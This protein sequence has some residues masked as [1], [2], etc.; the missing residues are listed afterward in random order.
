[1]NPPHLLEID[2]SDAELV[3]ASLGGDASSFA[4]LVHRHQNLVT[5]M[6]YS[7]IGRRSAAEE[8]AQEAFVTAWRQ[9]GTL[10]DRSRLRA[11][12]A[13]ITRNLA[14]N[15]LRTQQ[16]ERVDGATISVEATSS[17]RS[18]DDE[19]MLRD[20]EALVDRT[21]ASLPEEYREVLI[22]YYRD[23][24]SAAVVGDALGLSEEAV[25][26]RLVRGR[27][28][29]Q[30]RVLRQVERTLR[31]TGPSAA[32]AI[33]VIALL[34]AP[35]AAAA[36]VGAGLSAVPLLS[37]LAMG[38]AAASIGARLGMLG[39]ITGFACGAL[40]SY[41][42]AKAAFSMSRNHAQT[43][44]LTTLAWQ[45]GLLVTAY[46][47]AQFACT[48]NFRAL[49]ALHPALGYVS[50]VVLNGCYFTALV[51]LIRHGNARFH[52]AAPKDGSATEAG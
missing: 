23:E 46:I 28:L 10:K 7:I 42:G 1:M 50:L 11:W 15:R 38:T 14:L 36:S 25:R 40:G 6:A 35:P 34:P 17:E 43:R 8:I 19:A 22:L 45:T 9:L 52:H 18:P 24:Q 37:S 20:E 48:F 13:G 12:L 41:V 26:Q 32:F 27:R 21:L 39:A 5:G 44:I 3:R 29:L 2:P 33:A 51:I 47:S 30:E 49:A 4:A 16:R 31:R